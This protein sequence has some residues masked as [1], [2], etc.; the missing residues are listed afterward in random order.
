MHTLLTDTQV[1]VVVVC[2]Q[3]GIVVLNL[4]SFLKTAFKLT[5]ILCVIGHCLFIFGP[6]SK[7]IFAYGWIYNKIQLFSKSIFWIGKQ[8]W[9]N[10]SIIPFIQSCLDNIIGDSF[11]SIFVLLQRRYK[12]ILLALHELEQVASYNCSVGVIRWSQRVGLIMNQTLNTK[13]F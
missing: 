3:L 6:K 4:Q 1:F 5:C 8:L 13:V 7:P 10:N 2:H 12:V 11:P 9:R